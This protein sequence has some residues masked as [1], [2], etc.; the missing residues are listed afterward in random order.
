MYSLCIQHKL[1]A[2]TL[3]AALSI[4]SVL[5]QNKQTTTEDY[6]GTVTGLSFKNSRQPE[7]Q[8]VR[9]EDIVWKRDIYRMIDLTANINAAL[10]YPVEASESHKNLFSTIFEAIAQGNVKAYEYLDGREIFTDEYAI[11]FKELLKRFDVPYREKTDPKRPG[12][13]IFDIDAVDIPTAEVTRFY[14]KEVMY[15]DQRNSCMQT[16]AVALCPILI[17]SDDLGETRTYPMFWIPMESVKA[18]LSKQAIA[19][20]SLNSAERLTYYDYFNQRRYKGEIFKVSNL[21][22]QTIYQYCQTPEAIKAEQDRLEK[23]LSGIENSLWEP[24]QKDVRLAREATEQQ[25]KAALS[26]KPVKVT[27]SAEKK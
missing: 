17:R 23:E 4:N 27:V 13:T 5:G 7:S 12:V 15:L 19:P 26:K 21:K 25:K 22:N 14:V 16:K 11:K 3:F 6:S 24:N 9:A 20:D 18:Y 10:Y 2:F 1:I 8:K